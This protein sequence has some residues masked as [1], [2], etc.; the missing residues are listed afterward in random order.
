MS[1]NLNSKNMPLNFKKVLFCT[2]FSE[3]ADFAF[4]FAMKIAIQ[5]DDN[6]LFLL[7]VIPE[8]QSQFSRTY[9][10]EIND[11]DSKARQ[12][13][14]RKIQENYA[15]KLPE[16]FKLNSEFRIGSEHQEILDFIEKNNIDLVVI[17]RSKRSTVQK[18]FFGDITEKIARKSKCPV[19][20][21][22]LSYNSNIT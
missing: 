14:D 19:L 7:H 9:I 11:V 8:P 21:V 15:S 13:I 20:I 12:D 22:P 5:N 2:D 3:S 6:E 18:A 16:N 10:Y 4:N 17:G 1:Q